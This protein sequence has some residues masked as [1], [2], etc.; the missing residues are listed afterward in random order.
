[1]KIN[2]ITCHKVYNYGASL[3]AFALQ[4]YLE[5]LNHEV[6]IINYIP[7]YHTNRYNPFWYNRNAPGLTIH[8]MKQVPLFRWIYAPYKAWKNG[9][10]KTWK[11][12]AAFDSF[13]KK[14]YHLTT[15]TYH[16]Y[17]ELVLS[18]P[19]GECY[20]AG[21]DQI[22][23]TYSNNGKDEA[24]YLKFGSPQTKRIAY[25]ASLATPQIYPGYEKFVTE[26]IKQLDFISLR[27]KSGIEILRKLGINNT[28]LV[29]DPVFLLSDKEWQELSKNSK[30]YKLEINSYILVYD[31]LGNDINM[32]KF[33]LSYAK[34]H[35]L[36]I[37]S[38][39]DFKPHP[40]ANINI[41]DA[42]PLEFVNLIENAQC[43]I[44]NSFHATAFSVILKK[45]FYTFSLIGQNNSSRMQDFLE[46]T[47]IKGR[48]NPMTETK[49]KIDYNQVSLKLSEQIKISKKFLTRS[50]T[51]I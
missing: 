8:L 23:N 42:G 14:Y 5:N 26:N 50:L 40:Y 21:S 4:H 6:K 43:I 46:M 51:K 1:M 20:I 47:G 38:I 17:K 28:N 36:Q 24:Y 11:R 33:I 25:A 30:K 44:G 27:E 49:E 2:T 16:T 19:N 41:N 10:F 12:K 45:E 37:V 31:F 48:M 34:K 22:W 7:W 13:E 18:P 32:Q 35:K 29:V 39:N 15:K 3:Q 9:M